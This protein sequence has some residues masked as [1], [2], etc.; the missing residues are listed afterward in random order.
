MTKELQLEKINDELLDIMRNKDKFTNG[1]L[2]GAIEAQMNK[3]YKLGLENGDVK[4]L[5][6]GKKKTA[7]VKEY[8]DKATDEE[9]LGMIIS[10]ELDW[11]GIAILKTSAYALED[12]N[13]HKESQMIREK[14]EELEKRF[15]NNK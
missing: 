13:F 6:D 1:D 10:N 7:F 3:A 9:A 12:A 15:K 14:A 2:Q 4:N 5:I 8:Q 11:D